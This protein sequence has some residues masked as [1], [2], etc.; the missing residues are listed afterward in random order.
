MEMEQALVRMDKVYLL[1][2][3]VTEEFHVEVLVVQVDLAAA[4]VE[5]QKAAAAAAVI[6]AAVDQIILE[7]MA[8]V[9]AVPIVLLHQQQRLQ[10]K[11]VMVKLLFLGMLYLVVHPLQEQR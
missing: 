1:L 5:A 3:A 4:A 9:A 10:H 7:E 6:R 11:Q 8:A 2:M